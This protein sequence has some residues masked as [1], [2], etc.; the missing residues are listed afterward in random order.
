MTRGGPTQ[1]GA[2]PRRGDD[3]MADLLFVALTVLF[4]GLSWAL[5]GLCGRL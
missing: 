1:R 2:A 5:V 3:A 4:F